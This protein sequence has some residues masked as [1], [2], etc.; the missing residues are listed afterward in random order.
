MGAC[1]GTSEATVSISRSVKIKVM[2]V[3]KMGQW[4]KSALKETF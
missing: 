3:E 4:E 1:S 2:G